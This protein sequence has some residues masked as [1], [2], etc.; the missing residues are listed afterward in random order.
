[1]N[2]RRLAII[3]LL[4]GLTGNGRPVAADEA[5]HPTTRSL[6]AIQAD[7]RDALR[8]EAVA[9]SDAVWCESIER[10]CDLFSEIRQ[11]PRLQ[12]A[13]LLQKAAV[14]LRV[15]LRATSEEL[16][17]QW[18]P[19][20]ESIAPQDLFSEGANQATDPALSGKE[21]HAGD[22]AASGREQQRNAS[23]SPDPLLQLAAQ[24]LSDQLELAGATSGGP[25]AYWAL[26]GGATRSDAVPGGAGGGGAFSDFAPSLIELIQSTIEPD[27]WDVAGGPA[28]IR[29]YRPVFALVVRASS[30]VHPQIGGFL[31]GVRQ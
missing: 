23:P 3:M 19:L 30:H 14:R 12:D 26:H 20:A 16:E 21:Q 31:G 27:H 1:M 29:Y 24:A 13:E 7:L 10:L 18:R 4:V 5:D 8:R 28:T 11:H 22:A 6:V 2:A 15:R 17:K 25:A 9:P